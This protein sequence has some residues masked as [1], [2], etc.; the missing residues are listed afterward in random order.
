[1]VLEHFTVEP[2]KVITPSSK[3]LHY[4]SLP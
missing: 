4:Y 1:M 2:A 3:F